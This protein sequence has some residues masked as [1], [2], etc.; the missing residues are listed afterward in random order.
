MA[1]IQKIEDTKGLDYL[2][3]DLKEMAVLRL[4][5]PEASLSELSK[6]SGMSRSGVNHRLKKIVE[7]ANT[8]PD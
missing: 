1:A 2:K 6:L 7:I 5:N 4:D 3:N 8:I